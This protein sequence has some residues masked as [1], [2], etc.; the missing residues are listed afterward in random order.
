MEDKKVM[1]SSYKNTYDKTSKDIPLIKFIEGVRDGKWQD[2]VLTTRAKLEKLT[3]KT[4]RNK[5]KQKNPLVRLSGSFSGQSDS[6]IIKHSGFIAIDIDNIENPNQVKEVIKDDPYVYAASLS[7]SGHG[8]F[9]IFRIDG[10]RHADAFD[11]ISSYLRDNYQLISDQSCKNVSR[12]RYVSYDPYIVINES[13][14]TFKKYLPKKK[15]VKTNRIVYV[16]TDLD[17]IIRDMYDRGVN[18]C[19]DYRDWISVGYAL[20]SE[21]GKSQ[22]GIDYYQTLSSM[23]SKYNEKDTEKQYASC[24]RTLNPNKRKQSDISIIYHHAKYAGIELYSQETKEIVR[25][26]SSQYKNGVPK[27]SIAH[28]LKK[29]NDIDESVSTPIIEQVIKNGVEYESDN[30]VDDI[31]SFIRPYQLR[32]NLITRNVERDG[33]VLDDTELNSIYLDCK[34]TFDKAT[35]DLVLSTIFSNRIDMYNPLKEFFDSN[36]YSG[37]EYP[38]LKKLL[39][40]I[41]SDTPNY[42]RWV[43]KWLV[44]AV[45]SA[46]GN[47]S[48]LVLVL[49]GEIQGTGKT[50]FFRYLL[51]KSLRY[52]FAESKMDNGKD[53]EILMTKKLIILDDE[54]GGKS[55]REEKK[56]K[57][58]TSKEWIN[59]REPYGRV[60]VDLRR[61]C[62]FCGTSNDTQI[63]SDPTG[64]RR[65]LPVHVMSIDRDLYNGCIKEDLWAELHALYKSG[66]DYTVLKDDIAVLN[67]SSEMFNA[68]TPEE[69]LIAAKLKPTDNDL[70]GEWLSL[71]QIIQFLILDTKYNTM[72][73]TRVGMILNKYG[74]LKKRMRVN[75]V[76]VTVYLCTKIGYNSAPTTQDDKDDL[77]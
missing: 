39:L 15:A 55:K 73:N 19:E 27:E 42:D 28:G 64:N 32:K 8:L 46:F 44:S 7:I 60:S 68:S 40:S 66:Y 16:K 63:I 59:V 10:T 76:P 38:N 53:D 33:K 54:Y 6:D 67:E 58:I 48:P 36:I 47:Y 62:V 31:V 1:I 21:F 65:I 72:N 71:T 5:I 13:A 35:K 23:S 24:L 41:Q 12:A 75:K 30:I 52:L 9:V 29:F 70:H 57:E 51:P 37:T 34:S 22:Q 45:A 25:A 18:I 4:E 50:H 2:A 74:Y 20:A 69:E 77:F 49:S 14:L 26:A 11:A 61:L 17:R 3:D 56:L 43:T